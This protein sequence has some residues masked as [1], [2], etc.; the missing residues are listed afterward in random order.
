M[1]ITG[2]GEDVVAP[3]S[4]LSSEAAED[5]GALWFLRGRGLREQER[6]RPRQL[7][8]QGAKLYPCFHI[9][10]FRSTAILA[11]ARRQISRM[12]FLKTRIAVEERFFAS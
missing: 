9:P 8:I 10:L 12:E 7:E 11:V 4:A 1:R 2:R 5:R 6:E 3:A